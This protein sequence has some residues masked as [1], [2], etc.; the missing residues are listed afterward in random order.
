MVGIDVI[1]QLGWLVGRVLCCCLQ[2]CLEVTRCEGGMR[3]EGGMR[4]EGGVRKETL[5][6]TNNNI[7]CCL[8]NV[9]IFQLCVT[10][11]LH[12]TTIKLFL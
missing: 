2:R 7:D 5:V 12:Q 3:K 9:S 8:L 10:H 11:Q 6:E 1:G 4:E